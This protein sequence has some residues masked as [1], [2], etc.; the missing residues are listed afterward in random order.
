MSMTA[1][2]AICGALIVVGIF[3]TV[4]PNIPGLLLSW[5]AVLVWALATD[6]GVARWVVLGGATLL[7]FGGTIMK[8]LLPGRHLA[9]AGVPIPTVLFGTALGIVGFFLVPLIGLFLGF[10]VGVFVAELGRLRSV[11]EAWPSAWKAVKAVGLSILIEVG[12]GLI[13]LASWG[14]AVLLG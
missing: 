3:G 11:T 12:A 4:L 9:K 10:V 6:V 2:N 1:L 7:A 13:I 8:Y 14:A 5:G